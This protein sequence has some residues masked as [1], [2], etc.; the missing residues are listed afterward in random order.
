MVER[1]PVVPFVHCRTRACE[2]AFG[3]GQLV[4]RVLVGARGARRVYGAL[5]LLYF[6]FR[7]IVAT[8]DCQ[9]RRCEDA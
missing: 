3:R 8:C 7:R 9:C 5:G 4:V 6:E 1:E 2:R